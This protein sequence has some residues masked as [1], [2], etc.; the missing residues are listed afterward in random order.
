VSQNKRQGTLVRYSILV[1]W[2]IHLTGA[3]QVSDVSGAATEH[4]LFHEAGT[5][6]ARG[7][8]AVILWLDPEKIYLYLPPALADDNP[9]IA[10][11]SYLDAVNEELRHVFSIGE[12]IAAGEETPREIL[13]KTQRELEEL[14]ARAAA[15]TVLRKLILEVESIKR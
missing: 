3:A 9:H 2:G 4:G 15:S 12:K 10:G 5:A 6:L 11:K 8:A 14:G 13:P 1:K 7:L